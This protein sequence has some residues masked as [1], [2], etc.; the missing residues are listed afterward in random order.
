VQLTRVT[1]R[2]ME[3]TIS[4]KSWVLENKAGQRKNHPRRF[5]VVRIED[6]EQAGHWTIKRVVGLP[7]E[8]V[9]LTNGNLTVNG[10]LISEPHASCPDDDKSYSWWLR[11][12]EYVVLGDNRAY[13]TDSRKFGVIRRSAIRSRVLVK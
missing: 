2:S 7:G 12:D 10:N 11:D 9:E 13:S 3:P 1:G 8:E 5:D 6:P 4:E